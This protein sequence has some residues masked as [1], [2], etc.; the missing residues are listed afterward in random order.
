MNTVFEAAKWAGKDHPDESVWPQAFQDAYANGQTIDWADALLKTGFTQNYSLSLSS[1]TEKSQTYVSLN[2]SNEKGQYENDSYKLLS[3][4]IRLNYDLAKWLS[5]GVHS[6]IGY[7]KK[8][9]PF[10]KIGNALRANPF[11]SLY[12]EDGTPM[13]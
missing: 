4:S 12:N 6:Q 9:D 13:K 8:S 7:H 2:Y 10:S 11:G 1:G 5:A 3:S